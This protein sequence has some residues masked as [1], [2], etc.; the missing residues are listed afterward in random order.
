MIK[1]KIRNES[2]AITVLKG[3]PLNKVAT[4]YNL[5]RHS[6]SMITHKYCRTMNTDLYQDGMKYH[7]KR[8]L[9]EKRRICLIPTLFYLRK[10]KADFIQPALAKGSKSSYSD[11]MALPDQ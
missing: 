4:Q 11:K 2:I 8:S 5:H 10:N 3:K 1:I 6:V 9:R 7:K